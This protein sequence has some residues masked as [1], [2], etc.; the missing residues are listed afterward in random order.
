MPNETQIECYF[1][2]ADLAKL[3]KGS[4]DIV[5][6]F[7]ATYPPGALPK[8]EITANVF[9]KSTK[10]GKT[11]KAS[12]MASSSTTPSSGSGGCPSPCQ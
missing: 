2:S 8:F 9:T 3:C 10:A 1:K 4:K 7:K 12:L 6:N 11:A 5:I